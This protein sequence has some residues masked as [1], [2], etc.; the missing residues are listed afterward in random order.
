MKITVYW[1]IISFSPISF[2]TP[3]LSYVISHL[4]TSFKTALNCGKIFRLI[5][6]SFQVVSAVEKYYNLHD[7]Q[8]EVK[9]VRGN[10]IQYFKS[11]DTPT[12]VTY[13]VADELP[14]LL[15]KSGQFETLKHVI[16]N[17]AIFVRL[18]RK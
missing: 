18:F 13:R 8:N 7:N 10:L 14:W 4:N 17:V 1:S 3:F 15:S 6:F 9:M 11:K 16:S 2:P 12:Q 5:I